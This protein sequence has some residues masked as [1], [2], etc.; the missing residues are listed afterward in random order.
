MANPRITFSGRDGTLRLLD[1]SS[2]PNYLELPYVQM[3]F[4]CG[5]ISRPRPQD[6]IVATE[7]GY[8]HLP[9]ANYEEGFMQPTPV[10]FTCWV[11]DTTNS[12]KLRDALCNPD[13]DS[14]W[15]VGAAT[16]TSAKGQGTPFTAADGTTMYG[17]STF[18][19]TQKVSVHMEVL[20]SSRI[21]AASAGTKTW[22]VRV[23]DIYFAP[24]DQAIQENNE[25]IELTIKGMAYGKV[26]PIGAFTV[27]N[28]S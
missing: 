18:F 20:W 13:L 8:A 16:W 11:D 3:N 28:A 19:D 6:P 5:G 21:N 1:G 7:D 2:T 22:G 15:K 12:W 27:G 10:S 14:P 4:S 17:P 24:Q 26:A 9:D 23:N 25:T